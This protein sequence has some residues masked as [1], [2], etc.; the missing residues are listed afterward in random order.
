MNRLV[1]N[2]G[3][4]IIEEKLTDLHEQYGIEIEYVNPAYSSQTCSACNYVDSK[5]RTGEHFECGWCG[6]TLHADVNASRNLRARRSAR[7]SA[8]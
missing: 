3:R 1:T 7:Q 4:R 8:P 2:A 5:N 6:R